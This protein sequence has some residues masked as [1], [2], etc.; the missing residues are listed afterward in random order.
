MSRE[1][2]R[3]HQFEVVRKRRE[4]KEA[5]KAAEKEVKKQRLAQ[6]ISRAPNNKKALFEDLN[7]IADKER[8]KP[9]N[10]NDKEAHKFDQ[11]FY[12]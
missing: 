1:E 11:F 4:E 6:N 2:A 5:E 8:E 9:A 10:K 3:A 12:D 7:K